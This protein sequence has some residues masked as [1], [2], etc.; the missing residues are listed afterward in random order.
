MLQSI[1]VY[2]F[3][4]FATNLLLQVKIQRFGKLFTIVY[5]STYKFQYGLAIGIIVFFMAVRWDVGIDYM[6]YVGDY[7][8]LQNY[9]YIF[10]EDIESGFV[11][12]LKILSYSG[13]HF[14]IAFGLIA[15]IQVY[16]TFEYFKDEKFLLPYFSFLILTGNVFFMWTNII[17]HTIVIS[18]F[19]FLARRMM[20][21]RNFLIYL[22]SI[23]FLSTI[24]YS[25]LMLI[26]FYLVFFLRLESFNVSRKIQYI[27]LFGAL[28]LS[29]IGLWEYVLN[30]I[31]PILSFMGY[32]RYS[33]DVLLNVGD[34][35]M[36]F[37]A[38]RLVLLIIDVVLIYYSKDLRIAF[39]N[40]K[41]GLS[42]LFF[43][44]YYFFMPLFIDNMAFSRLIDY[45]QIGRV[46]TC[47]Y[48]LFYL[49][50]YKYS[51]VNFSIGIF[52]VILYVSHLFIQIYADSGNHTD[53]IRYHFFWDYV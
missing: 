4:I 1:L 44:I 9:G 11:K 3:I 12:F 18:L 2:G 35:E 48:L 6:N 25:A 38:R 30:Y 37:G 50:K 16:F 32:D 42:Y 5:P 49:F 33:S 7:L 22:L 43:M 47:S 31:D 53:C 52:V 39:P 19:L 36:N 8:M 27:L 10:R 13:F 28:G 21:K 23:L 40:K 34:R 24:H 41:F 17:R 46:L 20:I 14:T 51:K 15:F 26:P 29:S 45:F